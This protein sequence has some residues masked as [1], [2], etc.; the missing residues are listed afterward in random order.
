MS[1][2]QHAAVRLLAIFGGI[3]LLL[4]AVGLYGVVAYAVSQSTRELGVRMALGA[5][6]SDLW[7]GVMS[8]GLGL[9]VL[10]MATGAALAI[11]LTRLLGDML[12]KVSPRDPGAFLWALLAM[13]M[14]AAAACSVPAWRAT[15]T[16]PVDALRDS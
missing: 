4:A 1:W 6:A 5:G 16:D 3:A 8:H 14:V 13:M 15:R 11:P 2:T 10:G 7:R 9:T 12:Y